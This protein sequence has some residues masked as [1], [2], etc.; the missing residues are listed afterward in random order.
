VPGA[1]GAA[2]R[3]AL[4]AAAQAGPDPS[5]A[6]GGAGTSVVMGEPLR[7]RA[8]RLPSTVATNAPVNAPSSGPSAPAAASGERRAG[9]WRAAKPPD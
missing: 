6:S 4:T 2:G 8:S 1:D 3:A 9:G 7:A 5:S